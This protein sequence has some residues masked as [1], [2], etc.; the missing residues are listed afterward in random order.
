MRRVGAH[1][2]RGGLPSVRAS[3]RAQADGTRRHR[4][5]ER[6]DATDCSAPAQSAAGDGLGS[7]FIVTQNR[8]PTKRNDLSFRQHSIR[9][10]IRGAWEFPWCKVRLAF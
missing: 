2:T 7:R 4:V 5:E 1:Q 10:F 6:F 8:L 3:N 9:H